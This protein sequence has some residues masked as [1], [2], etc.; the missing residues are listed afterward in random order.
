[1]VMLPRLAGLRGALDL[2]LTGRTITAREAHG[3]GLVSRVVPDDSFSDSVR[4][5]LGELRTLSPSVLK[6][7]R[8]ALRKIDHEEFDRELSAVEK[9]YLEELMQTEDAQEGIRAFLEKR[10][11]SWRVH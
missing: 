1:M 4:N 11:P 7:T 3:I 10:S 9:L 5:F 6:L 8:R 2:I